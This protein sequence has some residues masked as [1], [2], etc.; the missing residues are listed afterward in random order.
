MEANL[1]EEQQKAKDDELR[2]LKDEEM[3]KAKARLIEEESEKIRIEKER[4]ELVYFT[5]Q[6]FL[7]YCDL[8]F[9]KCVG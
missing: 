4:L 2:R 1:V 5:C 6:Y 8:N 3:K 9:E 7:W